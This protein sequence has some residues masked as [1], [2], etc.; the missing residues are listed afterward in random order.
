MI[1]IGDH[2]KIYQDFEVQG[3]HL[4]T[5]GVNSPE[6]VIVVVLVVVLTQELAI[7]VVI[8]I[9]LPGNVPKRKIDRHLQ[10]L[11]V[12]ILMKM[13]QIVRRNSN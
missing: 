5:E 11:K 8:I 10:F 2:R 6:M 12:C 9:I 7:H 3:A 13:K 1:L 4:I